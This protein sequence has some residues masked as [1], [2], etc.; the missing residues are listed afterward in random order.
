M[1]IHYFRWQI[2]IFDSQKIDHCSELPGLK[3]YF[4]CPASIS[5]H[6]ANL[7]YPGSAANKPDSRTEVLTLNQKRGGAKPV[8]RTLAP[9]HLENLEHRRTHRL[10]SQCGSCRIYQQA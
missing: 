6:S 2:R 7:A 10:S 3:R 9:D 8:N 5:N 4:S 1:R